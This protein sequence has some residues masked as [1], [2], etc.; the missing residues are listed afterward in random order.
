M[1]EGTT[2]QFDSINPFVAFN[3]L[4]YIVFT[5]IYPTLVQYDRNFKIVRRLGEELEDLARTG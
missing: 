2:G 3:A 1:R 4:P 5:N